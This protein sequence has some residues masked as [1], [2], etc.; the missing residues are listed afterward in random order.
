MVKFDFDKQKDFIII[1]SGISGLLC[2]YFLKKRGCNIKILEKSSRSGGIIETEETPFG[3]IE[4]AAHI[5][6]QSPI[7]KQIFD[8]LE[9]ET[10]EIKIKKRLFLIGKKLSSFPLNI[11]DIFVLIFKIC[12][13]LKAK[14]YD[15]FESFCIKH[16]G[17]GVSAK[18]FTPMTRGIYAKDPSALSSKVFFK[19]YQESKSKLPILFF[20]KWPK[21]QSIVL[22]KGGVEVMIEKLATYLQKEIIYNTE[23]RNIGDITQDIALANGRECN[24]ILATPSYVSSKILADVNAG[25]NHLSGLSYANVVHLWIFFDRKDIKG[26]PSIGFLSSNNEAL[27]GCLF[28]GFYD[29]SEKHFLVTA[30]FDPLKLPPKYDEQYLYKQLTS[31][32]F[33]DITPLYM[34]HKTTNAA[35]PIYSNR[36]F[37][38]L[39]KLQSKGSKFGIIGNYLGFLS[40]SQITERLY[41]IYGKI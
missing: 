41:E 23:V 28:N 32:V 9:I 10:E 6:K 33:S 20:I 37:D 15:S 29:A 4:H 40:I 3:K 25:D 30:I 27:L 21:K 19:E 26:A 7:L 5:V 38:A 17:T 1:G 11:L 36:L 16:F 35:I 24:I 34:S 39:E 13:I 22:I 14:K 8:D 31:V 18:V 2:G 12:F